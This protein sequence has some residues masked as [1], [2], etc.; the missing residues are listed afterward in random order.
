MPRF[1]SDELREL[2][3]WSGVVSTL[4]S[5][6]GHVSTVAAAA[7]AV[8]EAE[9]AD[10]IAAQAMAEGQVGQVLEEGSTPIEPIEPVPTTIESAST[11]APVVEVSLLSKHIGSLYPYSVN[12]CT[13]PKSLLIIGGDV[14]ADKFRFMDEAIDLV[15]EIYVCGDMCI[16][17]I[18]LLTRFVFV[19]YEKYA[20][21]SSV[22]ASLLKKAR[23]RGCKLVWPVDVLSCDELCTKEV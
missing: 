14:R 1:V 4:P 2:F 19:K 23:F 5:A 21:Y 6:I 17:F 13:A 9:A 22:C 18:M 8:A 11:S 10:A 15:D 3:L 7:V 20:M 12:T 16:P